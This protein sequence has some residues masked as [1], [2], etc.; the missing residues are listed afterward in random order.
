MSGQGNVSMGANVALTVK[1]KDGTTEKKRVI[2]DIEITPEV[3]KLLELL[4]EHIKDKRL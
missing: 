1:R 4:V 3:S 2:S